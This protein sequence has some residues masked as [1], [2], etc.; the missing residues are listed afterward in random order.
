M[1][2]LNHA[3]EMA[4]ERNNSKTLQYYFENASAED[5]DLIFKE[6]V[7]DA[8]VLA[9]DPFGNYV[10]QKVLEIGLKSHK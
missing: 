8:L 10:I 4:K 1:E 3:I 7:K 2:I 5:K 9:K 6:L